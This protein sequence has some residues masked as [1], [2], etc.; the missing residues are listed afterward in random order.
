M[1][2]WLTDVMV[3]KIDKTLFL[4]DVRGSFQEAEYLI[5]TME[6]TGTSYRKHCLYV[7]SYDD[8]KQSISCINSH[9]EID[10]FPE[11][12]LTEVRH[13]FKV[14]CTGKEISTSPSFNTAKTSFAVP[15]NGSIGSPVSSS[16][17]SIGAADGMFSLTSTKTTLNTNS[18]NSFPT[19]PSSS[20]LSSVSSITS[21][22]PIS[23]VAN[24]STGFYSYTKTTT[25]NLSTAPAY[26]SSSSASSVSSSLGIK[27]PSRRSSKFNEDKIPAD[28]R[29]NV[30]YQD[31]DSCLV[32]E[33]DNLYQRNGSC[34]S[35]KEVR[36]FVKLVVSSNK[37][38]VLQHLHKNGFNLDLKELI[39]TACQ[40][41]CY[42]TTRF[43]MNFQVLL[44]L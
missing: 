11:V 4:N 32:A 41:G 19:S 7:K 26:I 30:V 12:H 8:N 22:G 44:N 34:K 18:S 13:F 42:D 35:R 10:Q 33:N 14:S 17:T 6:W 39:Y 3:S 24:N 1:K 9:G 25:R 5:C 36:E 43:I 23:P 15:T 27:G 37:V 20:F 29:N 16:V 28:V 40:H 21:P 2:F 31:G 38:H